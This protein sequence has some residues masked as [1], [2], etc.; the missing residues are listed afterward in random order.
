MNKQA[1]Y[2]KIKE[3]NTM[4]GGCGFR[5]DRRSRRRTRRTDRRTNRRTNRRANVA[6]ILAGLSVG[7]CVAVWFDSSGF[8][9]AQFQGTQGNF[10]LFLIKGRVVRILIND[11]RAIALL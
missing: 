4:F 9:R 10:A 8:I 6:G 7:Q 11:I 2:I 5:S 3:V 1:E